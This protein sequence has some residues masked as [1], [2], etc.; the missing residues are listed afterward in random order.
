MSTSSCFRQRTIALAANASENA[1][2]V[3]SRFTFLL[4]ALLP[5]VLFQSGC[6]AKKENHYQL[7]AEVVS[8][9]LPHKLILV[10]H[11]EIPGLMPAMTMSYSIGEPKQAASLGPRDRIAADLVV[12]ENRGRLEKIVLLEKAKPNA[13]PASSSPSPPPTS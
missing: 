7:Q 11:G 1:V 9:D 6:R 5:L 4:V 12:S 8:V 13:A 10:K 3:C 2:R